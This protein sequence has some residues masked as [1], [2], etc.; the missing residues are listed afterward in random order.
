MQQR[1][2]HYIISLVGLTL[3]SLFP[4]SQFRH[5][6]VISSSSGASSVC[7]TSGSPLLSHRLLSPQRPTPVAPKPGEEASG[8]WQWGA[9]G[10]CCLITQGSGLVAGAPPPLSSVSP[11]PPSP[12]HRL[13][14]LSVGPLYT[15]PLPSIL[16]CLPPPALVPPR[17]LPHSLP[18]ASHLSDCD[19]GR[20]GPEGGQESLGAE[21]CLGSGLEG[22][23]YSSLSG[24]RNPTPP[25]VP[26]ILPSRSVVSRTK[27]HRKRAP[28]RTV[29]MKMWC[30]ETELGCSGSPAVRGRTS[31]PG[32]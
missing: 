5:C 20:V 13:L 2:L 15:P 23:L 1:P 26:F 22:Q 17:A 28:G 29:W 4:F 32:S 27:G 21:G 14:C 31:P 9:V 8:V 30:L 11:P 6:C 7:F 12:A 3:I 18:G 19:P 24:P 16:F 25:R 10:T